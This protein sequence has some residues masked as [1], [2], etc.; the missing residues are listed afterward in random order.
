MI[1]TV[2]A[3]VHYVCDGRHKAALVTRVHDEESVNLV[4]FDDENIRRHSSCKYSEL[5][6]NL[7]WH[8]PE[9][10]PS[11]LLAQLRGA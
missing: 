6:H 5:P 2:G 3:I 11:N 8:W 4:I 9:P 7:T 1:P 10:Q